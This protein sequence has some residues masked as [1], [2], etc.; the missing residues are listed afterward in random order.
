MPR[1]EIAL[2][3]SLLNVT[4]GV[5]R[6]RSWKSLTPFWSIVSCVNAVTLIGTLLRLSSCRVAVTT[7][8]SSSPVPFSAAAAS[9]DASAT[10]LASARRRTL[11]EPIGLDMASIPPGCA[12]ISSAPRPFGVRAGL[13]HRVR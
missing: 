6:T 7:I 2:V 5:K 8:S 11:L 1:I 13:D 10:A 12:L 4:P 3:P 9:V